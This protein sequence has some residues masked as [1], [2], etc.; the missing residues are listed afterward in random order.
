MY[1][2]PSAFEHISFHAT[3]D[4]Y[5][6]TCARDSTSTTTT[7]SLFRSRQCLRVITVGTSMP[8]PNFTCSKCALLPNDPGMKLLVEKRSRG[9]VQ[10][11]PYKH[12]FIDTGLQRHAMSVAVSNSQKLQLLNLRRQVVRLQ[13]PKPDEKDCKEI[14]TI[15]K[16]MRF[17]QSKEQLGRNKVLLDIVNDQ[18]RNMVSSVKNGNRKGSRYSNATKEFMAVL[19]LSSGM[20]AGGYMANLCHMGKR[21]AQREKAKRIAEIHFEEGLS[22]SNIRLVLRRLHKEKFKDEATPHCTQVQSQ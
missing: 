1:T 8:F 3:D 7:K 19:T 13:A 6:L 10:N 17:L 15:L 2:Q 16:N 4:E 18:L 5:T 11:R 14:Q 12:D 21:A 22:K 20:K 9:V